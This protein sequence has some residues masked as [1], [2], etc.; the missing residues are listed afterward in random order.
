M[1][2]N[3]AVL[4][5]L[6]Q[7]IRILGDLYLQAK[8]ERVVLLEEN[9]VLLNKIADLESQIGEGQSSP[10]QSSDQIDRIKKDLDSYISQVEHCITLVNEMS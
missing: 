10:D 9:K 3:E 6:E 8:S 7:K 2:Y 4:S 1:S 5:N